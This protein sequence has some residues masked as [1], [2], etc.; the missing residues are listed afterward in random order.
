MSRLSAAVLLAGLCPGLL[1]A[2]E[3]PKAPTSFTTAA[4]EQV[5]QSL[6][7]SDRADFDRVEKG[8]IKRPENLVI[9]NEDGTVAWQLGDYDFIKAAKD[10]A[11]VNPS[12]MRQAQLN[13]SYG[14]FKV[15]DGIY[16]VR[17]FDLANTTFIE[18]KTGWIVIDTLTTPATSKAAYALVSQELGQK[19]IRAIIYSHAH[20][21]HFGGVKGLVSQEQVDKGE[22]QIIA[23]KGFMEAAI[24]ENVLAGNAMLRRATYQYGTLLPKGPNG[25]VDM[26]IGK[27]VAHGPM[28]IIAPTRLIEGNLQDLEI[29]G[30]PFTFQ[31]TPGTE[32]PAEMNVWLPQQKALLMA[33][34]VTATLHNLYTLRGA[35]IRDPLGWSKYINEA[36]HRFGDQAEVMFAVHNW[37]RWG[38]ED[39]VRTLEKQR[40]LYGY[41]NDQTLHL[42]NNGVTIN[43]IHE[44]LKVPP[45]LANE[46]FN[47][48]YHGSVS[49]NVRA[50]VNKYL[51]YYDGNPATLNPLAPEDSAVKYVEFMGGA[52]HLLQMAKASY[53]KGEYRWVVEVVNKLVFADPSNQAARSLQADALEQLGYQAENA[54]WR[55][56]YLAAAQELR[57]G[58]PRDLPPMKSGSPDALAAMDTGLL[59]DYLGVRLN[60]EKAEG[61][62]F[63]INLVLPDKNEQY[64]LEL[65]NSHLNNIKGVQSENAGQTVTI[66]RADLNRL[67]LKEVSPVRLVF[68]GKLKSS[69][70]PLLLAKLFGMLE[71]F[72][73]WFDIVTPP[74]KS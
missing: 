58:V 31:N 26:A 42:A 18:G 66:D 24:K 34:N 17:G 7:F 61:E 5:R 59:F 47:R 71:D 6:P 57:N 74:E 10:V 43:Q 8:L 67:M 40:D 56:S 28:S 52:D 15:T 23:P 65:K 32:S 30:V 36:L 19:P 9:K 55:N 63:A 53:D 25:Q 54:G 49:H 68:E 27:G 60:A 22:V 14:L 50:V 73:F 46:W 33:E 70:N 62:D 4:Q 1:A 51:G 2:A 41:L 3:Q 35:E 16:Q 13:L 44:R 64:L 11:S 12:L 48:G 20:I 39:I 45:E 21:D 72:N 38:H 69:G 29:D 37:P